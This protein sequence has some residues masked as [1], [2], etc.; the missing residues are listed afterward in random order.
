MFLRNHRFSVGVVGAV[1]FLAIVLGG[2]FR[3]APTV[4]A[5]SLEEF[6]ADLDFLRSNA[7]ATLLFN[8]FGDNP[9]SRF[10]RHRLTE[11][12]IRWLCRGLPCEGMGNN[13]ASFFT[14]LRQDRS[15]AESERLG[16]EY[17]LEIV[18]TGNVAQA[19]NRINEEVGHGVFKIIVRFGV[20]D[21]GHGLDSNPQSLVSLIKSLSAAAE[22]E[23]FYAIAG[24]NE[25]DLETWWQGNLPACEL[26]AGADPSKWSG[27][28]CGVYND[29][30]SPEKKQNWADCTGPKLAKYMNAICA[31]KARGDIPANVKLLSPAFNFTSSSFN[32]LYTS[33]IKAGAQLETGNCL[34]GIAGNLYPANGSVE[35][36][37][38]SKDLYAISKD[39]YITE[40]GPWENIPALDDGSTGSA[41]NPAKDKEITGAIYLSP[42]LDVFPKESRD[43]GKIRDSLIN[44][45]YQAYCATPTYTIEPKVT[46][47]V[48]I[49]LDNVRAGYYSGAT[50]DV[51]STQII[52]YTEA[53]TPI[54]RDTDRKRKLKA[55]LE[56][57]FGF[58]QVQPTDNY[59]QVEVQSSAINSL[60]SEVQKCVQTANTLHAQQV[61]CDKLNK[62][63]QCALYASQVPGTDYTV[64]SLLRDYEAFAGI[65]SDRV[66]VCK[67]IVINKGGEKLRTGMVNASTHL[68]RASRIAF[69][70]AAVAQKPKLDNMLFNFFSHSDKAQPKDEVLMVAF[71]I[72]DI[73]TNK[74]SVWESSTMVGPGGNELYPMV[75]RDDLGDKVEA[76]ES[77]HTFWD[78]A[79][80][81]TRN[82][83]IPRKTAERFDLEG[84]EYRT[85]L[86]EAAAKAT[87]QS[88]NSLIYCLQGQAPDGTGSQTCNDEVVKAVVDVI[89]GTWEYDK[90]RVSCDNLTVDE[91]DEIGE[92]AKVDK[93][94]DTTWFQGDY[95]DY[96]L[97]NIWHTDITSQKFSSLLKVNLNTWPT[98]DCVVLDQGKGAEGDC[99][100]INFYLVYPMG[101]DLETLEYVM[102][103]TF[104]TEEQ[105]E[106]YENDPNIKE[107]FNIFDDRVELESETDE[108]EF[109][110]YTNCDK[111]DGIW[112][113][114]DEEF[115]GKVQSS[116]GP[117]LFFGGRLGFWVREIQKI[118]NRLDSLSY[119]YLQNCRSTEEFLLDECGGKVGST[120]FDDKNFCADNGKTKIVRDVQNTE[121]SRFKFFYGN[122]ENP[123]DESNTILDEDNSF[124]P[125]QGETACKFK[126]SARAVD[127]LT[128]ILSG[129]VDIVPNNP[130]NVLGCIGTQSA[131]S[132]VRI[133]RLPP[134]VGSAALDPEYAA[135]GSAETM[136]TTG[137][138]AAQVDYDLTFT[139]GYYRVEMKVKENSI[140]LSNTTWVMDNRS[141]IFNGTDW[142][143]NP[144][145]PYHFL[146]KNKSGW[147]IDLTGPQQC[148]A[149]GCVDFNL[150][151]AME[152][153]GPIVIDGEVVDTIN[154]ANE[155]LKDSLGCDLSFD[156]YIYKQPDGS[157]GWNN[158]CGGGRGN[159]CEDEGGDCGLWRSFIRS[160]N[161]GSAR[162]LWLK[163][164]EAYKSVYGRTLKDPG[165]EFMCTHNDGVFSNTISLYSCENY[166]SSL[167][168]L[169]L[170]KRVIGFEIDWY[171]NGNP[172]INF[173]IPPRNLWEAI[174]K[175][176]TKHG[177]DK[178]LMLALAS[179]EGNL[180]NY[181]N[182]PIQTMGGLRGF[183][184]VREDWWNEWTK[185]DPPNTEVCAQLQPKT[186]NATG[187]D[188][189]WAN[190][191]DNIDAQVDV[192]CRMSLYSGIQK[193]PNNE[194]KFTQ[195]FYA[196]ANPKEN[197]YNWGWNPLGDGSG[198]AEYVFEFWNK[199][200][201]IV[202]DEDAQAQ[203]AGYPPNLCPANTTLPRKITQSLNQDRSEWT[204]DDWAIFLDYYNGSTPLPAQGVATFY[205]P[206]ETSPIINFESVLNNRKRYNQ[207]SSNL[208]N[209]CELLIGDGSIDQRLQTLSERAS[210]NGT[211]KV[212]G[213]AGMLRRGDIPFYD[214]KKDD[215]RMIWVKTS[216]GPFANRAL[217]PI[218]VVD[219]GAINDLP[220]LGTKN[221]GRWLIDLDYY[222]FKLLYDYKSAWEGPQEIIV[223]DTEAQCNSF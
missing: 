189:S 56:E 55:D 89:N 78:D 200:L 4:K 154:L 142:V 6:Q 84:S 75:K 100:T 181:Y 213:C 111:A 96:I 212:V 28:N 222:T 63:E 29:S 201:A 147:V 79:M 138:S 22:G 188:F 99:T 132:K 179:S 70:V 223:C 60:L 150:Q 218:A 173:I 40:T 124:F 190:I 160:L 161:N 113:C 109:K 27:C 144:N 32:P 192:A 136:R 208:I 163:G 221:G 159:D 166:A 71:R 198:Q 170:F 57:Y 19:G 146:T 219:V 21:Q 104:L 162:D 37:W 199:I 128:L 123:D 116:Q 98:K 17:I 133:R 1:I 140:C 14:Q 151:S 67:E 2:L 50:L 44:Q 126:M 76:V 81:L 101:Y 35:S 77:G 58:K 178:W 36:I 205:W 216:E 119:I 64:L 148:E 194:E 102:A 121:L 115:E 129:G 49:F 25:P 141:K 8:P 48:E 155:Y 108:Y 31:A 83:L 191:N 195:A 156:Y 145:Y 26:D 217:G 18:G 106:Q 211:S 196:R 7:A 62:P 182:D 203:P 5:A 172:K 68:E 165:D 46:G 127:S 152:G 16:M 54:F 118:F 90:E 45:G 12:Q 184:S 39:I 175:A 153:G 82:V 69:L 52:D 193:Y 41:Y 24:P 177:C 15:Y 38:D 180:G 51:G 86:R 65:R 207:I 114:P 135:W 66:E 157:V 183:Y 214:G 43:V 186:F 107:R 74:G 204:P 215:V 176:S 61:M 220:I 185:A 117:A 130:G 120:A 169:R 94:G 92:P 103:R 210:N 34:E 110:D 73:G 53:Q 197:S 13:T 174:E 209:E 206:M 23:E 187:L 131:A 42:I 87:H 72:P 167:D 93:A 105:F 33:M 171:K 125:K 168:S 112:Y 10:E 91:V 30:F 164:Y 149:G 143:I 137:G 97:D 134:D 95:G 139:P 122:P 20:G 158:A 9:D 3:L 80:S 59:G 47:A 88:A 202:K 85:E 11:D